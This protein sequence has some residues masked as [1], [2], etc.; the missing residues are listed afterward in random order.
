M[1]FDFSHRFTRCDYI[2]FFFNVWRW[3]DLGKG[4]LTMCYSECR[5]NVEWI[6]PL[7]ISE[8]DIIW[9]HFIS[10]M[11]PSSLFF[12]LLICINSKKYVVSTVFNSN[13]KRRNVARHQK[14]IC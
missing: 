8:D 11:N 5:G 1:S 12:T 9:T 10:L 7:K 3:R 14:N 13:N 2:Y 4:G 6:K